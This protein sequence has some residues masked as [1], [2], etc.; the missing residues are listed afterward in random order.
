MVSC[1][2]PH[3]FQFLLARACLVVDVVVAAV[4]VGIY[5][6]YCCYYQGLD[7]TVKC[8]YLSEKLH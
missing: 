1:T 8:I 7:V 2:F 4:V 5:Y 6:Y 3:C